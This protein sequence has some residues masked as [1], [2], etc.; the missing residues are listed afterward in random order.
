MILTDQQ[1]PVLEMLIQD[2]P[3][4]L[5]PIKISTSDLCHVAVKSQ[6]IFVKSRGVRPPPSS[7][8]LQA[9]VK[10]KTS[11]VARHLLMCY[12]LCS[13]QEISQSVEGGKVPTIASGVCVF[14]SNVAQTSI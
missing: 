11:Q 14:W 8:P 7:S 10:K 6:M 9:S 3:Y 4:P 13:H 2:M 12:M 5:E 1:L